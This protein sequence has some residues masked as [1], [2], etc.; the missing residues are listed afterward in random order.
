MFKMYVHVESH[1]SHPQILFYLEQLSFVVFWCS[2]IQGHIRLHY[3]MLLKGSLVKVSVCVCVCVCT[4][5]L[6]PRCTGPT[7][8]KFNVAPPWDRVKMVSLF[9]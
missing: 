1:T 5:S 2:R 9:K 8:A 3:F 6:K 7:E 4:N